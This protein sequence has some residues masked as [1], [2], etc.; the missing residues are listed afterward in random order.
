MVRDEIRGD[1]RIV[2]LTDAPIPWPTALRVNTRGETPTPVIYKG[3]ARAIRL[4]SRNAVAHWFGVHPRTVS[5]W[6]R[7]LGA[8][9]ITK[10]TAR[11]FAAHAREGPVARN[12]HKGRATFR[13]P[14]KEAE[15][16][17]KLSAARR[18]KP[19]PSNIY[20][21]RREKNEKLRRR[22]SVRRYI[23]NAPGLNPPW[24]HREDELVRTLAPKEVA[25][26]T[27]RTVAA[28]Y[29]RR[30]WLRRHSPS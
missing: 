23:T 16:R 29:K 9:A 19:L 5:K 6:R 20:E 26:R 7:A 14:V 21:R 13:N 25:N 15:R 10:G 24:T 3:L 18:G 12:L 22:R 11:L 17:E 8:P 4:E 28:V 2:G 1:V 27:G 30:Q